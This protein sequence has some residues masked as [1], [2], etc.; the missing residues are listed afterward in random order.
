MTPYE[1]FKKFSSM[2]NTEIINI[3]NEY[4]NLH[5]DAEN[6]E[7]TSKHR[8]IIVKIES[9]GAFM[10]IANQIL[11][12]NGNFPLKNLVESDFNDEVGDVNQY[13]NDRCPKDTPN[14]EEKMKSLTKAIRNRIRYD[15][16]KHASA[17]EF[18]GLLIITAE[19]NG[20]GVIENW[21][22]IPEKG[23]AFFHKLRGDG[24]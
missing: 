18:F 15:W 8:S 12:N 21:F 16:M 22:S 20:S 11:S 13:M 23:V 3:I 24:K 4:S 2:W 1:G 7:K 5:N 19:K 10:V 14:R 9:A 17:A 6:N